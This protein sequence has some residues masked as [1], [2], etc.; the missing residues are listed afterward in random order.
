M[1][2]KKQ[3]SFLYFLIMVLIAADQLAKFFARGMAESVPLIKNVFHL[4][5]VQNFGIAFGL[6]QG[7]NNYMIWIYLIVLGIVIY[8]H[9]KFP[10]DKFSRVMLFFLIAGIVG[11][12]IDRV[13]FGYVTDFI[14]FRIWPVF[15]FADIYLNV[16]IIGLIA[17]EIFWSKGTAKIRAK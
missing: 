10:E 2:K 12:L 1:V 8:F 17:K 11:N 6:F 15:N 3:G 9:D 14:D 7:I 16:G 5:F 13:A 4:T